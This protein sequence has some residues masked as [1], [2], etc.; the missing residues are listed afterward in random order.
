MMGGY[1]RAGDS[2]RFSAAAST[3]MACPPPLGAWEEALVD[4]LGKTRRFRILAQTLELFDEAGTSLA[5]LEAVY[6]R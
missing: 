4:V 2:L 6:L 1:E 3:R 5:S